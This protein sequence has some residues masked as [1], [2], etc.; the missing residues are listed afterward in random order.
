[1]VTYDTRHTEL[2]P[3]EITREGVD[4]SEDQMHVVRYVRS[5]YRG[6][7][8]MRFIQAVFLRRDDAIQY[9]ISRGWNYEID[10]DPV[11]LPKAEPVLLGEE[12]EVCSACDERVPVGLDMDGCRHPNCPQNGD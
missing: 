8:D 7:A 3:V 9:C 2:M 10:D 11:R 6:L 4:L 5:G 1:M 12:W